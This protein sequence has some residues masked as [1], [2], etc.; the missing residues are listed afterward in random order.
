MSVAY[1]AFST[2]A[3]ATD[4]NFT[5]TPAGTP[6]G[7]LV[8]VIQQG[9]TGETV[10]CT[11]GGTAMTALTPI[12]GS[13][14]S[15][16][17]WIYPFFLGS[18][19]PTGAQTVDVQAS[20]STTKRAVCYTVTAA[21]DAAVESQN[22]TVSSSLDDPSVTLTT[23]AETITFGAGWSGL[24]NAANVAA[25]AAHTKDVGQSLTAATANFE[26]RSGTVAAGSPTVGFVT[27]AADDVVLYGVAVKE[28]GGAAPT[29]K[30]L[31]ALGV[32]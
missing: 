6:R 28:S 1:D 11:Y 7:A 29:V 13:A 3:N 24:G 8:L 16:P 23:S 26:H 5:H 17:A 31:A 4:P 32:G 21:A 15:E 27:T 12:D 25:D 19:V 20:G 10:T 2:G 18:S 14:A 22:S 9:A 30:Q